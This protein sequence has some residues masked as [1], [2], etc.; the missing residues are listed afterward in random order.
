ML[1]TYVV[2]YCTNS[3]T[4]P[5]PCLLV[6]KYWLSV[7][8]VPLT[9]S[10]PMPW[11]RLYLKNATLCPTSISIICPCSH[12]CFTQFYSFTA[13]LCFPAEKLR[14]KQHLNVDLYLSSGGQKQRSEPRYSMAI[15][16]IQ[17]SL[18]KNGKFAIF[19]VPQGNVLDK[20][21]GRKVGKRKTSVNIVR[22]KMQ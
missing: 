10:V 16:D 9:R 19:I 11:G 3:Y 17:P 18:A 1:F 5:L 13:L 7:C 12:F 2:L 20:F 6:G 14:P 22:F 8:N 21:Y 15:V 4:A